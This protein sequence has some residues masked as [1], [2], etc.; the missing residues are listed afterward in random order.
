MRDAAGDRP[1][2]VGFDLLAGAGSSCAKPPEPPAPTLKGAVWSARQR[3]GWTAAAGQQRWIDAG[4]LD[5]AAE[6]SRVPDFM[7]TDIHPPRA[8]GLVPDFTVLLRRAV[9]VSSCATRMFGL[10]GRA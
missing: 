1:G 2:K 3:C 9:G 10:P 6:V 8:A 5:G 4:A 7:A